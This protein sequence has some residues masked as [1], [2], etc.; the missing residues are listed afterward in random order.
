MENSQYGLKQYGLHLFSYPT[1]HRAF[2]HPIWLNKFLVASSCVHPTS[3][4]TVW[5]LSSL[6]HGW[7][8]PGES[9]Q[10]HLMSQEVEQSVNFDVLD[11]S[12]YSENTSWTTGSQAATRIKI[13]KDLS[14]PYYTTICLLAL[15][16]FK[17][18]NTLLVPWFQSVINLV[19]CWNFGLDSH[20]TYSS[21]NHLEA[22]WMIILI[23]RHPWWS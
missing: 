23:I 8:T 16:M 15:C 11:V 7:S 3:I 22:A 12:W 1:K 21:T 4:G 19:A 6:N 10:N 14:Q 17:E 13:Y 9:K 20:F 18:L 5:I 2:S